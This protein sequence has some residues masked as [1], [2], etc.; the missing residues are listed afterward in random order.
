MDLL[1]GILK[2]ELYQALAVEHGALELPYDV[3]TVA[4][5]VEVSSVLGEHLADKT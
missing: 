2:L 1:G 4:P 3:A 5:G